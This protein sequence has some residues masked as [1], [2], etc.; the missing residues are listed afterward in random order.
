MKFSH[1]KKIITTIIILL[2]AISFPKAQT[3]LYVPELAGFDDAMI[4]MMY[5]YSVP[6]GQ[7][8]IAYHGKLVYSRG[9]GFANVTTQDSVQPQHF[10]AGQCFK[11][12]YRHC[13]HDPVPG[14]ID[15]S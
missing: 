11:T 12:D 6:G 14:W 9:F 4:N 1:V 13:H 2:F 8:A 15:K 3:G 7:L 5:Q 10:P